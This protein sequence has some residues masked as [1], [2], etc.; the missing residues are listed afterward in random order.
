VRWRGAAQAGDEPACG[1]VSAPERL[2][3]GAGLRSLL[4]ALNSSFLQPLTVSER[5]SGELRRALL[6]SRDCRPCRWPDGAGR[7]ARLAP[8]PGSRRAWVLRAPGH[9]R[10][11]MAL[12]P[13]GRASHHNACLGEPGP[14]RRPGDWTDSDLEQTGPSSRDS[15]RDQMRRRHR[16][17]VIHRMESV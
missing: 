10:E 17:C 13:G 8:W 4:A 12:S 9:R 15:F 5:R 2:C 14:G 7:P 3:A 6:P 16:A 1:C 11:R